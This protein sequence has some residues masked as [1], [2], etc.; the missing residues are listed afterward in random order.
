MS[1]FSVSFIWELTKRD[2][3]ERFA[4]SVLGAVWNFIWPLVQLFIYIIIFGKFM[5]GRLPG[6]SEVYAYGIYVASGL[7][8]WTSFSNSIARSSRVF[9]DKKQIISKVRVSLP[10]M[11]VFINLS[12]T[13]TFVITL[14]FLFLVIL[15]TGPNLEPR[16]LIMLPFIYFLQQLF[17]LALGTLAGIFTVFVRDLGEVVG[18]TLQ[19]W[20]WF[21]PIVY[22]SDILPSLAQKMLVFNPAFILIESYHQ[23]FVFHDYLPYTKLMILAVI[24]HGL[25]AL[26]Y[27]CIRFLEKDVRDF[28]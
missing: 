18:I 13:I 2:F 25:L 27:F 12:E 24:T 9:L 20:F 6:N 11:P 28:L 4:G 17:A 5:G 21:T 8:P 14:I 1:M 15:I 10:S 22:I 16:L 19:L 3:S 7:I 26:A 23:I